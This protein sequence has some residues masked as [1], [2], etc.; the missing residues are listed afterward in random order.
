MVKEAIRA[1][2]GLLFRSD[3]FIKHH[4]VS[5]VIG[6][7]ICS[8]E[9]IQG[10]GPRSL[11]DLIPEFAPVLARLKNDGVELVPQENGTY[12]TRTKLPVSRGG[13]DSEGKASG[14]N[15]DQ[16]MRQKEIHDACAEMR[17]SLKAAPGWWILEYLPLWE[18]H[19]THD[20][21]IRKGF[22]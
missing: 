8:L 20:G 15:L 6:R 1:E 5:A 9:G 21:Y 16:D 7:D 3:A 12:I 10:W 2:A 13:Q 14:S 17:D 18:R 22:V 4:G 11:E 19:V